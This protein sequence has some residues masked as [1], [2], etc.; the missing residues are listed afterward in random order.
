MT[1]A[2]S[3]LGGDETSESLAEGGSVADGE[4]GVAEV[5]TTAVS[6]NREMGNGSEAGIEGERMTQAIPAEGHLLAATHEGSLQGTCDAQVSEGCPGGIN[7]VLILRALMYI[8]M[9]QIF[10]FR[11]I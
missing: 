9:W 5:T 7:V 3:N 2:G 1:S 10:I 6:D 4:G 11:R 8:L